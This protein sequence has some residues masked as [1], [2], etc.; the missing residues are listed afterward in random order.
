MTR[1]YLAVML[2]GLACVAVPAA[3]AQE[4]GDA[5]GNGSVTV[6]DGVQTLRA[7][8]E[9]PSS[10]TVG[11]CDMD[12]NG[13]VTVTDGVSVLRKAAE[14]PA[15]EE[16]GGAA[17][18][19]ATVLAELQPLFALALPFATS[20]PVTSCANAPDGE[21]LEEVDGA[22]TTTSFFDC[23]VGTKRLDGDVI[24]GSG[25]FT[26]LFLDVA[27]A[28]ANEDFIAQYDGE[29]TATASGGGQALSSAVDD[30]MTVST[31]SSGD[32]LLTFENVLVVEGRLDGGS[33]TL[34]LADSDIADQFQRLRIEF[35]GTGT[36]TV[37]ATQANSGTQ[38]FS[39]DL[40]TG[41]VT[42]Q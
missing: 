22:D 24:V 9:L 32:S 14:L 38:S 23:D 4:C 19:P 34:D 17:G 37:V 20:K 36:A 8:A 1:R 10:C 31:E 6:T 16:C 42:P 25:L 35:N 21:I 12:G 39:Y 7:A 2:L 3:R 27:T 28:D 26:V 18:Q 15:S 29:L 13:S 11:I 5:D 30:P 41:A 33:A 40:A